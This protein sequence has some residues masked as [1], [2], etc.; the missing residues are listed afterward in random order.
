[1]TKTKT[2]ERNSKTKSIKLNNNEETFNCKRTKDFQRWL[3]RIMKQEIN[4][5]QNFIK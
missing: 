3:T 1:M 5:Y 4:S 2:K